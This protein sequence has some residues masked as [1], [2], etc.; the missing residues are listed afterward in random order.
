MST[1]ILTGFAKKTHGNVGTSYACSGSDLPA[2]QDL[3]T[4]QFS[5]P[6]EV[7]QTVPAAEITYTIIG[8]T[9]CGGTVRRISTKT[10]SSRN[11]PN[12]VKAYWNG[13][14]ITLSLTG[15]INNVSAAVGLGI[16]SASALQAFRFYVYSAQ[17]DIA[18]NGAIP[19]LRDVFNPALNGVTFGGLDGITY[20][21]PATI[22][23]AL[24]YLD[25]NEVLTYDIV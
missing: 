9:P 11:D 6:F 7:A 4:V 10:Y 20:G 18:Y 24:Y 17:P 1:C 21:N 14:S 16:N 3:G 15:V 19:Y 23:I 12:G 22:G 25:L 13:G 2:T 5:G 8:S